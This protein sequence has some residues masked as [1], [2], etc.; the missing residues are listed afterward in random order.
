MLNYITM[1]DKITNDTPIYKY[2]S[3]ESF[4][5]FIYYRT[6]MF[7]KINSWPDAYEGYLFNIYNDRLKKNGEDFKSLKNYFGSSWTFQRNNNLTIEEELELHQDGSAAMWESY[8]KNGGVRLKT[9]IGKVISI[10]NSHKNESIRN[11]FNLLNKSVDYI[12]K[13]NFD[14]LGQKPI[15]NHL[16]KKRVAFTYED[17]YRFL[18]EAKTNY[19]KDLLFFKINDIYDFVDEFLVSPAINRNVWISKMLY[20]YAVN[21]TLE[22]TDRGTNNKNGKQYCRISNLYGQ[23]SEEID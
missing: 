14:S 13:N 17:E 15:V 5:H 10:I 9:T 19:D 4:Y 6:I 3:I 18:L 21:I 16:F 1:E 20:H 2:L 22:K 12:A 8:C 11:K 7:N 23:I